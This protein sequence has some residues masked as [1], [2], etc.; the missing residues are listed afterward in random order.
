MDELLSLAEAA[1]E[2]EIEPVTLRAA[3]GRRRLAA[4][5]FGKT[6][7][8][9]R[10]EVERYR[11]QNL[12]KV[13]RTQIPEAFAHI[14]WPESMYSAVSELTLA[15][16]AD[17]SPEDRAG[18]EEI[19]RQAIDQGAWTMAEIMVHIWTDQRFPDVGM[20]ESPPTLIL[21]APRGSDGIGKPP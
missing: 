1:K 18:L 17:A 9:T 15:A 8:T 16:D 20:S 14:R 4:R 21:K 11:R 19:A 12:G 7:V 5:R 6:Y 2:L 3:I 13:G 10:S